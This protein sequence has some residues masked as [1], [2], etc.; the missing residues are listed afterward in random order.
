MGSRLR[1][2]LR[3]LSA[4]AV[5]CWAL[6]AQVGSAVTV[7]NLYRATTTPDP[8]AADQRDAAIQAAMGRVLI[9]VTGNRAAP[10]DPE[11]Q[12]MMT[13]ASRYLSS[14]GL[15]QGRAQ[16][17]FIPGQVDQALTALKKPIW[18][19]ERPLTLL[20]IAVDDGL[21]GRALL[22]ANDTPQLGTE[23]A[24]QMTDLVTRLKKDLAAVADERGLP[25]QWPL[26]DLE[27]LGA[28]TFADVW[29]GFEDRIAAASQRYRADAIL[30][31]RVRPGVGPD[32]DEVQWLLVVGGER[33]ALAGVEL[34]DGLDAAADRFATQFATVGGAGAAAI[35][36]RNVQT[37]AD[38]DRV[39]SYLERQS[40]LTD[41][42]VDSFDNGVLRLHVTA[43]GDAGVLGRILSLGT[44]LRPV[45]GETLGSA[46][47]F[48]VARGGAGP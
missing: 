13:D 10:L 39:I 34:R 41:V 33:Q 29:G 24:P 28:V 5:V 9:K 1:A 47:V 8:A 15:D 22:G 6:T 18:G 16:V 30:I 19:P 27:D 37:S 7:A 11:L 46:L 35:T 4:A 38:Y 32:A 21:G 44:V 26:L 2:F 40:V 23:A 31:G 45:P 43:R 42:D 20:W 3:G 12:S 48:E 14:Y 25:I 36:V 17:G